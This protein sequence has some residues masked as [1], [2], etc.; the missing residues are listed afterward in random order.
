MKYFIILK[1]EL[2]ELVRNKFAFAMLFIPLFIFPIMYYFI[3]QQAK[4]TENALLSEIKIYCKIND[5]KTEDFIFNNVLYGIKFSVIETS[6]AEEDLLSDKIYLCIDSDGANL[7][8]LPINIKLTYNTNSNFSTYAYSLVVSAIE[9][10]NKTTTADYLTVNGLDAAYANVINITPQALSA[11]ALLVMIA[12]MLITSLLI[13]G[14][15]GVA[16][17]IF[18]GEKERG[19]LEQLAI[20]QV[21]RSCIWYGKLTTVFIANVLSALISMLAYYI[22]ML[23]APDAARYLSGGEININLSFI[24]IL[25]LVFSILFFALFISSI[26]TI[27]SLMVK[28]AKTASAILAVFSMIPIVIS[29]L[30]TLTPMYQQSDSVMLIPIYNFIVLLR[31][32]FSGLANFNHLLMFSVS[33]LFYSAVICFAAL[34]VVNKTEFLIKV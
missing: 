28:N 19:T 32:L 18:A 9:N 22:S 31:L 17:D 26:L 14:G 30:I 8:E 21:K 15:T 16:A 3:G 10:F 23:I 13:S 7:S 24:T 12:P 2:T 33:Q 5:D 11:N 6:N 34:K 1:K 27:V 25:E 29:L 4:S 20:T